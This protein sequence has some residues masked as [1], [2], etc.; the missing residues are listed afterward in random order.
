MSQSP[1]RTG[2][3]LPAI[4]WLVTLGYTHLSGRD[5]QVEHRHMAPVLEDVLRARLLTL[6]PWLASAPGGLATALIELR[7]RV[8][9][10]LLQAN[11]AFWEQVVQQ[12][13]LSY[14]WH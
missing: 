11:Q 13:Q 3:E 4:A 9:G 1:E 14:K 10:D 12:K 8:L 6:N 5:V 2:V 7:K